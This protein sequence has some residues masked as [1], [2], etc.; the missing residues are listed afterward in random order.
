MTSLEA[1][2]HLRLCML[3]PVSNSH[4]FILIFIISLDTYK[5]INIEKNILFTFKSE[6]GKHNFFNNL[7]INNLEVV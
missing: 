5:V 1:D 3:S 7:G 2:Y 6:L 4:L